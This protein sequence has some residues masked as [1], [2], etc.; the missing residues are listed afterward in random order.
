MSTTAIKAEFKGIIK[1]DEDLKLE[2]AKA[3]GVKISSVDRW[4]KEDN[5]PL[6]TFRNLAILKR[7]FGVLEVQELLEESFVEEAET[8]TR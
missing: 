4:L 7:Y 2:I 5:E 6:T 3:N 8:A 1:K